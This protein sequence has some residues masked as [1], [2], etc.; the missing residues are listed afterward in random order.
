MLDK[1]KLKI[2]LHNYFNFLTKHTATS[3]DNPTITATI[4]LLVNGTCA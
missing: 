4:I 3:V 2:L 1:R